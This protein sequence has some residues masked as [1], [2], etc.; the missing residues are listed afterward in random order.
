MKKLKG[1]EKLGKLIFHP[2]PNQKITVTVSGKTN[3][4][5]GIEHN[6]PFRPCLILFTKNGKGITSMDTLYF[7]GGHEKDRRRRAFWWSTQKQGST[8]EMAKTYLK[9]LGF[10]PSIID[11]TFPLETKNMR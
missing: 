1:A 11:H 6:P 4:F 2:F 7:F 3:L 10:N 9:T 8:R 5:V